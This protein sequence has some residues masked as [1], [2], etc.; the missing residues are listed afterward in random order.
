MSEA[1]PRLVDD[2]EVIS[3]DEA[4]ARLR[5]ELPGA[6]QAGRRFEAA[7]GSIRVAL[8]AT[9]IPP[10][11]CE[12]WVAGMLETGVERRLADGVPFWRLIPRKRRRTI[13]ALVAGFAYGN[14]A[15]L[16]VT[17]VEGERLRV[18]GG[19]AGKGRPR[20]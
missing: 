1:D 14:A 9:G 7:G 20:R 2:G 6:K 11:P 13:V 16:A 18:A 8:E 15:V 17:A 4:R 3:I 19:K 5:R 10:D 12:K